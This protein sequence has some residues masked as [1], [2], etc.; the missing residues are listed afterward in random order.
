MMTTAECC[1]RPRFIT[2]AGFP[3]RTRDFGESYG[4]RQAQRITAFPPPDKE[5][6]RTKGVLPELE[7]SADGKF[8]SPAIFCAYSSAAAARAVKSA[9]RIRK[10]NPASRTT[11]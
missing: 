2:T 9:I 5:L 11:N 7:P 3:T 8:P 10:R 1:G 6:T 4:P